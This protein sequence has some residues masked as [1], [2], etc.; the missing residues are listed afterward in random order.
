MT[1]INYSSINHQYPIQP[2]TMIILQLSYSSIFSAFTLVPWIWGLVMCSLRSSHTISS[3]LGR[4]VRQRASQWLTLEGSNVYIYMAIGI[5]LLTNLVITKN[6]IA[7]NDN[8]CNLILLF[9]V[10]VMLYVVVV[11]SRSQDCA[12]PIWKH[13][14]YIGR[15]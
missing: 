2:V 6:S 15:E 12:F 8:Q 9:L 10:M 11:G 13:Q 14:Q 5:I 3:L 1:S 7:I 4:Q